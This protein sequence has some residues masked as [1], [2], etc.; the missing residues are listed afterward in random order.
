VAEGADGAVFKGSE[1]I[2]KYLA[3]CGI[4]SRREVETLIT[5]GL[6]TLDGV[7]LTTPA[8]KVTGRETILV[9]GQPVR[10]PEAT[11]LWRYHKPSGLVTTRT[12]PEGRP[13]VFDA[14]PKSLP[15]VISVGRLDLTTEGLL[16]LTNDG[17]LARTLELPA[18]G[19]N[20]TYRARAHGKVTPEALA[21]L[22][23]G[24]EVA[25][26]RYAPIKASLDRETGTNAWLRVE[27]SEGK[28][29]EVRRALEAVGLIV[30]RLIRISYGPFVLADLQ[31][32]QVVE[33]SGADLAAAL[34]RLMPRGRRTRAAR[35]TQPDAVTASRQPD[36]TE[37]RPKPKPAARRTRPKT[38]TTD[39]NAAPARPERPR[40]PKPPR[41][42]EPGDRS[43]PKSESRSRRP[44][45]TTPSRPPS[46][47]ERPKRP[48]R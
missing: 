27:L 22:A 43:G 14:L 40:K 25:G 1:R 23:A 17:E 12:D 2:A 18:T 9:R 13:T 10:P 42:A 19:L 31:P 16:L 33:V 45:A 38:G 29:R 21:R 35:R 39:P 41:R 7:V 47:P 20:R 3:R 6:V 36:F 32:G 24:V 8:V 4:A 11:R 26:E 30:N 5:E 46:R 34:G 37:G 44:A 28:K 48:P 15:R